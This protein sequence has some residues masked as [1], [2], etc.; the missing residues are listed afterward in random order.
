MNFKDACDIVL[1]CLENEWKKADEMDR[2]DRLESEKRAIMGYE[3][4]MTLYKA[5]IGEIMAKMELN[6]V[7]C[8]PWYKNAE[9]GIFNELYGLSGLAPWA[10]DE[11]EE[12]RN[13][14]S[15][16]LIGDKLYCLINGVSVLQPQRIP[17]ER[18]EQLK[19]ALLLATPR[20]RLEEGFHEVYLK[21]GIRIT[22]FSGER[23]KPG[24]DIMVFRKYVMQ[25]LSFNEMARLG[26]IP[27][28]AVEL[29][30]HMVK[31]GFNVIF[32]GP[33]RSGKTTFLQVWQSYEDRQLEGLAIATDPE[34]D[35]AS[36][37]PD[38]PIMQ[39]VADGQQ[40]E[41]ITKPLLR[42]D[43][44]YVLLEEMRDGT[45]FNI[46]LEITSIGTRRSKATVH[47]GNARDL[48][49][50]MAEKIRKKYGGDTADIIKRIV[51]NFDLVFEFRQMEGN[52]A[53]KKL[54]GIS[55]YYTDPKTL[56]PKSARIM[57]YDHERDKWIWNS[58]LSDKLLRNQADYPYDM[59][60][61]IEILRQLEE[62]SR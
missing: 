45:A 49:Y 24:Q 41:E 16:K 22:I 58:F 39:L 52:R 29:F 43:N 4:E 46:A 60:R 40:L 11:T 59:G 62:E 27:Q 48:P 13:S 31:V 36:I 12:Y 61:I 55:Q 23:T 5:K 6:D 32:A 35:W 38:A 30:E 56:K 2:M 37:M 33:V 15:A 28:K 1:E 19:R 42:G 18:R 14:S 26:T 57:S 7:E 54:V 8:P 34:T 47:T 9:E 21:N 50:M 53:V 25:R 3:E 20:E 44:D 10:Y 51:S 17:K